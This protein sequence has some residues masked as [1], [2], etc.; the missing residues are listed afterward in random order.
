[1]PARTSRPEDGTVTGLDRRCG[2]RFPSADGAGRLSVVVGVG[3]IALAVGLVLSTFK[4]E[5]EQQVNA[6]DAVVLELADAVGADPFLPPPPPLSSSP[7]RTD[8]SPVS[9]VV[10]ESAV[11]DAERM[12]SDLE[13]QHSA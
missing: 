12:A 7:S 13:A 11:C 5:V 10:G 6:E 9:P 4:P 3:M 8:A 1:M 2:C